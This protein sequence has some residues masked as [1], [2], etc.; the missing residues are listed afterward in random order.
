MRA[1]RGYGRSEGGCIAAF[2]ERYT[3][4]ASCNLGVRSLQ[5][6]VISAYV[7]SVCAVGECVRVNVCV[8][9]LPFR[10]VSLFAGIF[11]SLS[12]SPFFLVSPV[13]AGSR[14]CVS[15]RACKPSRACAH[16]RAHSRKVR[17]DAQFKNVSLPKN[18]EGFSFIGLVYVTR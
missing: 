16:A 1:E 9:A 8:I 14:A 2:C 13:A 17:Y 18:Y 15:R 6:R 7:I 5:R 4:N 12:R 10:F 11:F 3:C